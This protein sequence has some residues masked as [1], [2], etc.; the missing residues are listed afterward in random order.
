MIRFIISFHFIVLVVVSTGHSRTRTST[1]YKKD[2]DQESDEFM[3]AIFIIDLFFIL[4]VI[5]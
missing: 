2:F 1:K 3:F 4:C 5:N